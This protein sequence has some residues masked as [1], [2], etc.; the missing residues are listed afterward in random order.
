M[1]TSTPQALKAHAMAFNPQIRPD[2]FTGKY[3]D[4]QSVFEL[5][6]FDAEGRRV[7]PIQKVT[8]EEQ[9]TRLCFARNRHEISH[10]GAGRVHWS[11]VNAST[12]AGF[13]AL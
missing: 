10:S 1:K 8:G 5:A 13:S 2:Q 7:T 9:A 11:F 6:A 4:M 3:S 12:G